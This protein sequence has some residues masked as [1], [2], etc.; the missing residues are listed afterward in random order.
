MEKKSCELSAM[1]NN[2][3]KEAKEEIKKILRANNNKVTWDSDNDVYVI[4]MCRHCGE[5]DT[6]WVRG[7]E[8]V[9]DNIRLLVRGENYFDGE[10]ISCDWLDILE[11]LEYIVEE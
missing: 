11:Q 10:P 8:L 6:I 7:L 4:G 3:I 9:G 1:Y 2:C 5:V